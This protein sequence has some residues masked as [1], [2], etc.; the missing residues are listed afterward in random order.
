M[1]QSET[2]KADK[3]FN[4]MPDEEVL[5]IVND[6]EGWQAHSYERALVEAKT[7]DL[8]KPVAM[9]EGLSPAQSVAQ[10]VPQTPEQLLAEVWIDLG[11]LKPVESQ[12]K[13]RGIRD[14]AVKYHTMS[15]G[16]QV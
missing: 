10:S 8:F 12:D 11:M 4:D 16:S 3:R 7:R 13:W 1:D 2:E 6:R 14:A 15:Q 5:K 9:P